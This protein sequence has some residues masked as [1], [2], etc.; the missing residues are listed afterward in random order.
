MISLSDCLDITKLKKLCE[1]FYKTFEVPHGIMDLD[2]SWVVTE[3]WQRACTGYFRQHPYCEELCIK[4]DGRILGKINDNIPLEY[5]TDTCDHGLEH[6]C[7]PIVVRGQ[8]IGTFWLGQFFY[9]SP[10]LEMYRSIARKY[11]FD[12]NDFLEVIASSPVISRDYV[13]KLM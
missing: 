3:G 6:V 8:R 13:D 4:S 12:E 11:S 9:E 10:D 5:A 2:G 1:E 7:Y